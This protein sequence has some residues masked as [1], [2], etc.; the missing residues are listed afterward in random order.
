MQLVRKILLTIGLWVIG[1]VPAWFYLQTV[2][3]GYEDDLAVAVFYLLFGILTLIAVVVWH[4][5]R[6]LW[7][8]T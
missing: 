6:L 5:V 3:R 2:R 4:F 8:R 7:K 1:L